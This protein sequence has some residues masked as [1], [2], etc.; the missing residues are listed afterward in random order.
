MRGGT[1]RRCE[2]RTRQTWGSRSE[3]RVQHGSVRSE[4]LDGGVVDVGDQAVAASVLGQ[5][6]KS[7]PQP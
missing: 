1:C 7:R 5:E 2:V 6:A 3:A 4:G